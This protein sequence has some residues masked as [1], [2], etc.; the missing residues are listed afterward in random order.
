MSNESASL[1]KL[2]KKKILQQ[3][4]SRLFKLIHLKKSLIDW[5]NDQFLIFRKQLRVF[6]NMIN[7][8]IYWSFVNQIDHALIYWFMKFECI[9]DNIDRFLRNVNLKSFHDQLN[10]KN[11]NEWKD[12]LYYVM[13]ARNNDVW[14]YTFF[15]FIDVTRASQRHTYEIQHWD[16]MNVICFFINHSTFKE[17]LT[18]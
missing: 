16:M 10:F 2:C 13:H 6:L 1:I 12:R 4:L 7:V 14:N 18:Y 11:S 15:K 3:V 9:I 8:K 17:N 5:S